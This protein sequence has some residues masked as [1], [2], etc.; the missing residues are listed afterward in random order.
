M[1]CGVVVFWLLSCVCCCVVVVF[2]LLCVVLCVCFFLCE[3]YDFMV[4]VVLV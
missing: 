2:S 1:L 3:V 4:C